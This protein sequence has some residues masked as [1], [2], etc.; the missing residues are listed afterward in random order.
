MKIAH[1]PGAHYPT[2][3]RI[4]R[5]ASLGKSKKRPHVVGSEGAKQKRAKSFKVVN[6]VPRFTAGVLH[7]H[8]WKEDCGPSDDRVVSLSKSLKEDKAGL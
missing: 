7:S 6:N 1:C 2:V 5:K 3:S 4:W 8:R